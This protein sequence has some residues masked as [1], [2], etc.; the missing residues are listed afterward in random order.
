MR[1]ILLVAAPVLLLTVVKPAFSQGA[2]FP[3]AENGV[4][5]KSLNG[6]PVHMSHAYHLW[7]LHRHASYPRQALRYRS[8]PE[9][10]SN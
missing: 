10:P 4:A 8:V 7:P 5:P 1:C 6:P 2:L 3:D 9:Q